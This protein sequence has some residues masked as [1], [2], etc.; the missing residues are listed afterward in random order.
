MA[1]GGSQAL[2]E[3]LHVTGVLPAVGSSYKRVSQQQAFGECLHNPCP[4]NIVDM[5]LAHSV[6]PLTKLPCTYV[7][8]EYLFF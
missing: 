1:W 5:E 3:G 4:L 7:E 8:T 6:K 2:M